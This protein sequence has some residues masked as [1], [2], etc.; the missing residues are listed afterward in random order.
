M[1]RVAR[2]PKTTRP[3]AK[4]RKQSRP[5]VTT[6]KTRTKAK[7]LATI[8]TAA[9]PKGAG[10]AL[11]PTKVSKDELRAR[12][13]KLERTN[14]AL[15]AKSRDAVREAKTAAAR[16]AELEDQVA[17][18]DEQLAAQGAAVGHGQASSSPRG[19]RRTQRREIDP[20]DRAP[21]EVA[22]EETAQ[23]NP[24]AETAPEN[25]DEYPAGQ[26]T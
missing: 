13:E 20:G 22:V 4:G 10:T 11:A 17:W 1:A 2:T 14:A 6:A 24:A 9:T 21:P 16:I 3:A 15:R 12:V 23:P 25:P 26:Q 7:G 18:R 5:V 19:G 8:R